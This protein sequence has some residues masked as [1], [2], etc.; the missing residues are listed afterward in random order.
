MNK[1][2]TTLVWLDDVR[3][4]F[5]NDGHWLVFAPIRAN[6]VI[7]VKSY[8]EFVDWITENGLPD[9]IA[10]DHDLADVDQAE[11]TGMDCAKWLVD[12]CIDNDKKLPLFSSQS[13][14]PPGRENILGL[15]TNFNL[16]QK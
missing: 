16:S 7:W 5:E 6:E 8:N 13:A 15:L 4:P 2:K 10:F 3:D 9:G 14:N 11:K 1:N 12:Y